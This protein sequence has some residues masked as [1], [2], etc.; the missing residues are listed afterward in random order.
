MSPILS[1]RPLCPQAESV[2]HALGVSDPG[3]RLN[4]LAGVTALPTGH[5][6][7]HLRTLEAERLAAFVGGVWSLTFRGR[8][9]ADTHAVPLAA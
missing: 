5:V 9:L 1:S 7:R 4:E 6:G 2:L 3:L 8:R